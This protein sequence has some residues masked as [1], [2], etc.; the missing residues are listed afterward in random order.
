MEIDPTTFRV[1]PHPDNPADH[2]QVTQY[3]LVIH[4][5][6]SPETKLEPLPLTLEQSLHLHVNG[7]KNPWNVIRPAT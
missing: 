2:P 1:V 6:T 3:H 5:T 4:L 7:A